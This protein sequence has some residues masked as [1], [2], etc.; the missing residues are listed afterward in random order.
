MS[1]CPL[2]LSLLICRLST[3]NA[4]IQNVFTLP[5]PSFLSTPPPSVR[6]LHSFHAPTPKCR[7]SPQ[8]TLPP[9]PDF[10]SSPSRLYLF[11]LHFSP[12]HHPLS[13]LHSMPTGPSSHPPSVCLTFDA[14]GR[15]LHHTPTVCVL[16]SMPNGPSSHP[17]TVCV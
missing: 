4:H 6:V 11:Y 10:C 1:F 16:H 14:H 3:S 2:P 17:P 8:P 12:P 9:V 5:L 13:V 15:P 7:C